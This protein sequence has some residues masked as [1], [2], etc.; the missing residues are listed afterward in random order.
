MSNTFVD[1]H[2]DNEAKVLYDMYK[3]QNNLKDGEWDTPVCCHSEQARMVI[4]GKTLTLY[5]TDGTVSTYT[6]QS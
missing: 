4:A 5:Y 1:C 2:C 3:V 6:E